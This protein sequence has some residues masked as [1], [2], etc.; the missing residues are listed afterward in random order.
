VW[1]DDIEGRA[2]TIAQRESSLDPRAYN[3][4]CCYGLFQIHFEANRRFLAE[5]GITSAEQLY[6]AGTNTR[7]AYA[8]YQASGWSPWA[9]TDP[10]A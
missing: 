5:L 4:S 9:S 8:L 6:D 1:P 3:G 2:L 7:A 10:G